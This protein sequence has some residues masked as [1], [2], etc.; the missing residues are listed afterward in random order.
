[1]HSKELKNSFLAYIYE[2]ITAIG[3]HLANISLEKNI[4]NPAIAHAP[5]RIYKNQKNFQMKMPNS[6]QQEH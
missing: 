5:L 2:D 3:C 1:M 4:M 6:L